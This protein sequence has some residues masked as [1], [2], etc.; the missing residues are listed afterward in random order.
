MRAAPPFPIQQLERVHNFIES[1]WSWCAGDLAEA[2]HGLY[3]SAVLLV[4]LG[5]ELAAQVLSQMDDRHVERLIG[6]MIRLRHVDAVERDRVV[7]EFTSRLEEVPGEAGGPE[8]ARR[9]IEQA[10]GPERARRISGEA[11]ARSAGPGPGPEESEPLSL[12]GVLD[13]RRAWELHLSNSAVVEFLGGPPTEVPEHYREASPMERP[14]AQ[15]VQKLVHGIADDSVPYEISKGY[16]E[17][18]KKAGE[19][20]E[21]ITLEKIDH[22]QIIDPSS[23][24]WSRVQQI[25]VSLTGN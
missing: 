22:F 16:Y 7:E 8:Y 3:K 23:A 12:A 24:V 19:N 5:S 15:V 14:I 17:Q 1:N 4:S 18:K 21:L 2:R 9:V 10:V 11:G 13:L 25:F 6:E 20:V